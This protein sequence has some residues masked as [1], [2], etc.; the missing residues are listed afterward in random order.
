LFNHRISI[1][2]SQMDLGAFR[3]GVD[4]GPLAIRHAGLISKIRD[5]GYD[6]IDYGDI[7]PL[8]A[9]NEGNPR[10]RYEKEIKDSNSRLYDYVNKSYQEERMPIILGGDHSIAMGSISASL[11]H[12]ENVGV[13]WIDAHADFNDDTI[14]P[15]GNIHGMPLSAVCGCGPESLV[16]F[17]QIRANP[18]NAVIVGAR[19]LDPLEKIKL[20]EKGVTVFSISDVHSL[21]IKEVIHKAIKIATDK[22]KG[23]HLSFDMDALDPTQA[24]GV[25]TPVYNGLTQREAFIICEEM[26]QSN[27]LIAIDVVETNPLLDKR[28]MT[29]ILASELILACL[30][31]TEYR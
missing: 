8:V 1:I 5:A 20:K 2:G 4:M 14:T 3:K 6:V 26:H 28:N 10:M 7:V 27:K 25:G 24:P 31:N 13:I 18:K 17:S 22:T 11:T 21:G 19:A 23:I 15:S 30:G 9:N 16:D 12:Y 29:G